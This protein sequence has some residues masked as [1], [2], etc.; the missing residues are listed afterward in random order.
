[1]W[2]WLTDTRWRYA[3][4]TLVIVAGM[5]GWCVLTGR[6]ITWPQVAADVA[7]TALFGAVAAGL[8]APVWSMALSLGLFV[9]LS[10]TGAILVL[11]LNDR[12]FCDDPVPIDQCMTTPEH[13]R[14][15]LVGVGL[16][17]ALVLLLFAGTVAL[18]RRADLLPRPP[19]SPPNA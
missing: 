19:S 9:A 3:A 12:L 16:A 2:T 6:P 15:A 17:L 4:A 13:T 11:Y 10:P 18:A 8:R 14:D 5:Q 7:V 1:M